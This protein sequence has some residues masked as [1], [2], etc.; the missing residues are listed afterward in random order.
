MTFADDLTPEE[1]N[2]RYKA[3][4]VEYHGS[5]IRAEFMQTRNDEK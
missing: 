1:A 2:A 3:Y 5:E 4:L